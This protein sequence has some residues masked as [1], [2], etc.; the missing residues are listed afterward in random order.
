MTRYGSVPYDA[1]QFCKNRRIEVPEKITIYYNRK[2]HGDLKKAIE[3][4]KNKDA[5][6]FERSESEIARM[7]LIEGLRNKSSPSRTS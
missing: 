1:A 4:L 6:F 2:E 7:I 5:R 3:L